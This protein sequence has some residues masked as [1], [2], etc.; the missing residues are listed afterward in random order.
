MRISDIMGKI[1]MLRCNKK[2][3]CSIIIMTGGSDYDITG[4]FTKYTNNI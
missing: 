4:N 3:S 1:V 2:S